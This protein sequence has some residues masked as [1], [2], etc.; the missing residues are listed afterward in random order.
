MMEVDVRSTPGAFAYDLETLGRIKATG[1]GINYLAGSLKLGG[2]LT[3]EGKGCIYTSGASGDTLALQYMVAQNVT[4][5]EALVSGNPWVYIFG[6]QSGTGPKYGRH[7]VNNV[8]QY[9]IEG[10]NAILLN[11]GG[12][13]IAELASASFLLKDDRPFVFGNDGDICM[14]YLN[15]GDIWHLCDGGSLGSNIRMS[16]NGTGISWWGAT[17][18]AR[19]TG[20]AVTAAAIHAALV[21][22]GLITA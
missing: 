2:D 3:F 21:S 5:F 17:P 19:P 6:Y 9:L 15:T 16:S 13:A 1:L 11:A 18:I 14:G 8:G 22:Y 10:E 7:G 4:I 12:Y 20:V